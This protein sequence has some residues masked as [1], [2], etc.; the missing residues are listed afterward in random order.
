M[1]RKVH[2]N[3]LKHCARC[4]AWLP[5]GSF[6]ANRKNWDGLHAYCRAC[7]SAGAR[8]RYERE[9]PRLTAQAKAWRKAN[10]DKRKDMALRSRFGI[11][12]EE[13]RALEAAQGGTCAVC[14]QPAVLAV[15]HCHQTGRVRGLLCM[16]C[17][18]SIGHFQDDA[19]L[20][21]AAAEYV[22]R[23]R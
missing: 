6:H 16:P 23:T 12:L 2:R 10:P 19:S 18:T 7:M 20:I 1:K 22:E 11:T 9:A 21:R 4:D 15:D 14:R 17:N 3:G 13:Y 8:R 5:L